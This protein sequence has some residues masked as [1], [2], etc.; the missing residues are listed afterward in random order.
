MR[1]MYKMLFRRVALL[2]VLF[3]LFAAFSPVSAADDGILAK[4]KGFF[5]KEE[6]APAAAETAKAPAPAEKSNVLK[7]HKAS[8]D[9]PTFDFSEKKIG[10]D[11]APLKLT[12]FTS[13]TCG[14]CAHFHTH[15][16]PKIVDAYVNPGKM[17]VILA[18]FPLEN[19]AMTGSLVAHC[20]KG[21]EYFKIMDALFAKQGQWMMSPNLQESLFEVVRPTGMSE[22]KMLACATNEMALKTLSRKRNIYVMKYRIAATP[23]L[24]LQGYGKSE[25][26]EGAPSWQDFS[27]KVASFEKEGS[28][29][30]TKAAAETP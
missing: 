24:Y 28:K 10:S 1:D 4:I 14:H 7:E 19:R 23:T 9:E 5:V 8:P 27:D 3:A 18:D 20:F 12:I 15:M 22:A 26:I 21:D 13:L 11:E 30:T 2:G 25:K 17:Q 29:K 6:A 16:L